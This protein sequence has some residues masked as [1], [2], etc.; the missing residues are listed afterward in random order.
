MARR[1]FVAVDENERAIGQVV[2]ELVVFGFHPALV[3]E[4][5]SVSPVHWVTLFA[6]RGHECSSRLTCQ[7]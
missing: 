4:A 2:H 6:C 7:L 1:E 3:I 5:M